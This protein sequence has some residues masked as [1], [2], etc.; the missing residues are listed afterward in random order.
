[1]D[2]V[3]GYIDATDQFLVSD[4][5]PVSLGGI[6]LTG[7]YGYEDLL[8]YKG[9]ALWQQSLAK[10]VVRSQCSAATPSKNAASALGTS[11]T[12]LLVAAMMLLVN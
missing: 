6:G 9:V 1:M 2:V 3:H 4:P 7:S 10:L 5:W 8:K 11:I 12:A